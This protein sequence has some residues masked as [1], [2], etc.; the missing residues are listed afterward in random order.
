[1]RVES[2]TPNV[3]GGSFKV[4][5]PYMPI[6]PYTCSMDITQVT[7]STKQR[8]PKLWGQVNTVGQICSGLRIHHQCRT[9][10]MSQNASA[11][12]DVLP[13]P[14]W[15][16]QRKGPGR[17]A[18]KT[19]WAPP[20]S[21]GAAL[22]THSNPTVRWCVA[23]QSDTSRSPS[24]HWATTLPGTGGRSPSTLSLSLGQTPTLTLFPPSLRKGND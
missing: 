16:G 2:D 5:L 12:V 4:W 1:M 8:R 13:P 18:A 11:G 7:T 6:H 21:G 3:G 24:S 19:R 14:P 20:A 23:R 22:G 9:H 17:G 10:R 15:R